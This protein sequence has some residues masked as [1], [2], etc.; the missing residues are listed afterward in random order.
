MAARRWH[1]PRLPAP[2]VG[3]PAPRPVPV[4]ARSARP[5]QSADRGTIAFGPYR[6]PAKGP[7][8]GLTPDQQQALTSFVERYVKRTQKSKQFTAENRG[9]LADPRSVAGFRLY[10]KEM[11]YPIVTTRSAGSRL[12]DLDGNEYIDLTNG[13][14]MILF[15]HNPPFIREAIEAQLR[16]GYEIGPQTTLAADVSRMVSDMTGM[17]RVAFCNTGSEAVTAA[18]RVARTVSG[19]DRI[20]MFAG[21]YHGVSDE[22]LVRGTT[23]DG[24]LRSV[25]IA[26]GIAPNMVE[27]ILVLDYGS[28]ESLAILK[29]CSSELAAVLVEPVQSR[30]P[31]LQPVEFLRELRAITE[32]SETALVF[33]EVVSGFRAHQGGTQALYGIRADL[34]TYGKVVGGGL[35]IGLVTGNGKYMDALDGG[36]WRYGDDSFPEVGVTF[37]AGTFVRHPL[38]LAAAK[39]VLERLSEAGP[40]LQRTLNMRTTQ[41]VDE[42]NAHA[43]EVRA[44][45]RVT[46]FSSWFCFN[47]PPDVPYASLF[48]AYM[49][50]KGVHL[51]EGRAGFLT[52][53]HTDDD[54]AR[55]LLA[56]KE[57]LAEMQAAD[58]LPGSGS[59][60]VPGARRGHD[61]EGREAW[62]VPDP[63]REGKYLQVEEVAVAHV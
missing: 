34:A 55:I 3:I 54:L 10:W 62:F 21:A 22:V 63:E 1:P 6:P 27:N 45:L 16:Q 7:T 50:H 25:P 56:F 58:F 18:I 37:F 31:E 2:V 60:P 43:A 4:P 26:P 57:S 28:P 36:Q 23:V 12:W 52:T 42:L 53:A 41:F 46:A 9:Q 39:A 48:Y 13:F 17:E 44:P 15:G 35:P 47:F 32:K 38:A 51:W 5:E 29:D 33:D 8:G 24:Q 40:D 61:A 20:A 59:P 49:R 14:G 11:V 19:R 30:R